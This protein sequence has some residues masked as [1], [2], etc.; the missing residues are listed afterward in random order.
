MFQRKIQSVSVALIFM[1]FFVGLFAFSDVFLSSPKHDYAIY[2]KQWDS[3]IQGQNAWADKSNAYG[4]VHNALAL[5]YSVHFNLPRL[6]FVFLWLIC[7]F[8][9][10]I[11][12]NKNSYLPKTYKYALYLILLLNPLFW[13]FVVT[14]G[15][16]DILMAFFVLSS[17]FFFKEKKDIL[18]GFLMAIAIAVKYIPIIMLPFLI[19]SRIH[20]RWRFAISLLMTSVFIFG[21]AIGF[22]EMNFLILCK[23]VMK[24]PQKCYLFLDF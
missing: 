19:F 8:G 7:S 15:T 12:V 1:A 3:I 10:A 20:I 2:L 5:L 17:I 21:E 22:G 16:N 4:P 11:I 18:S 6:F 13:I 9:I 24:D 23:W 14:Y